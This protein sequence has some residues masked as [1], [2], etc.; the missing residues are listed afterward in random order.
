MPKVKKSQESRESRESRDEKIWRLVNIE[1]YDYTK[2]WKKAVPVS[3]AKKANWGILGK[4]ACDRFEKK[5]KHDLQKMLEAAGLGLPR[6]VEEI[7]KSLTQKKVELYQGK[8]VKDEDGNVILFDD[9]AIQQRG[10]EL[11]VKIHGLEKQKME[12]TG[13]DGKPV[14]VIFLPQEMTP[15]EWQ[16]KYGS[17]PI[18]HLETPAEAGDSA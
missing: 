15:E 9:N 3:K 8:I 16:K 4:R 2:A 13:E 6:V 1:G 11:L 18:D 10:R 14:G 5:H 12:L 7:Q 17:G